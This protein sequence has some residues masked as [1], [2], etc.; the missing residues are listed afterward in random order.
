MLKFRA[1]IGKMISEFMKNELE[2]TWKNEAVAYSEVLSR[3]KR[4]RK[5]T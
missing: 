3:G 4:L 1:S 2:K 5:P